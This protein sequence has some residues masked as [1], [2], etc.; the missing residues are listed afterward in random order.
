MLNA[1]VNL[2][3]D[4][5]DPEAVVEGIARAVEEGHLEE[6]TLD[7]ALARVERLR[8]RLRARFG[9][10]V[11][12]D[13]SEAFSPNLVGS[14]EHQSVARRIARNAVKVLEGTVPDLHT[15]DGLLTVLIDPAA[16]DE[17]AGASFENALAEHFP[18]AAFQRARGDAASRESIHNAV[19]DADRLLVAVVVKPAAWHSFGL[20]DE[21]RALVQNLIHQKPTVLAALGDPRGLDGFTGA[22]AQLCTYSDV[23]ASRV[24]LIEFL[25]SSTA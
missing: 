22:E 25:A 19:Q 9:E 4:L 8:N 11:F 12:T 3:L 2:F 23:P 5:R 15:G 13:P 24:A 17:G 1:G 21:Q 10:N 6:A 7:V 18:E 16:A 14:E 20:S